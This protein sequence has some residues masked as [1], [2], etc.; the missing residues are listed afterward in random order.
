MLRN[1][2]D[3]L[4][5]IDFTQIGA[6]PTC[7]MLLADMGARV[8]KVESPAGE[9]GRGLGPAWIGEDSALFHAFNR[10][11]LGVSLNLKAAGGI[12]VATMTVANL[13]AGRRVAP[14]LIQDDC[15]PERVAGEALALLTDRARADTMRGDLRDVRLKLGEPG[16][17]RR[18]AAAVL[19]AANGNKLR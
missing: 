18:A 19:A 3:G 10:N 1:A 2:L 4:T 7:T 11:K 13:I 17:S 16:A 5:V 6:G 9:L 8:L 14:E 15:T 12:A